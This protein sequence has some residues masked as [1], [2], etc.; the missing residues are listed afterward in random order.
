[1]RFAWRGMYRSEPARL[2]RQTT[3]NYNRNHGFFSTTTT[4]ISTSKPTSDLPA[5][6]DPLYPTVI[7][8]NYLLF[9]CHATNATAQLVQCGRWAQYWKF[10]GREAQKG[11]QAKVSS[12][13][14]PS[15]WI[16]GPHGMERDGDE[17]PSD[18]EK[19]RGRMESRSSDSPIQ[20]GPCVLT[21]VSLAFEGKSQPLRPDDRHCPSTTA[22]SV[23]DLPSLCLRKRE[24]H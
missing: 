5:T 12:S 7:P 17:R 11:I 6:P 2:D 1:M 20:V 10:G 19:A 24:S 15:D 9:A 23:P 22:L 8:R 4:T 14:V 21:I 3:N 13:L 18:R 16:L